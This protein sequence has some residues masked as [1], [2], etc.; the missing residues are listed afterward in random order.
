MNT[1]I[2]VRFYVKLI[3]GG[4]TTLEAVPETLRDAVSEALEL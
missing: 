3:L 1:D 2:M 4:R